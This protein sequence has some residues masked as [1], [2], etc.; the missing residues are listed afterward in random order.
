MP[1]SETT[2]SADEPALAYRPWEPIGFDA[3]GSRAH[4]RLAAADAGPALKLPTANDV[5]RIHQE[6]HRAGYD[7]GYDEGTARARMEAA[8]L[9]S[10]VENLE[11]SLAELDQ[12][13]ASEM[14]GLVVEITR[15][16]LRQTLALN[17][18]VMLTVVRDALAQ[19]PQQ[20]AAI[21]VNPEDAAL[22]RTYLGDQ[23]GPT[24][25]RLLEDAQISRGG[26]R[27]EAAGSRIDA[28]LEMRWRRVIES[29][30]KTDQWIA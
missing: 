29:L 24:G 30:G 18:E 6:A 16:V 5:E 11:K 7:A 25:H 4:S 26:C 12:E 14:L 21:H 28:T 9:N 10:L 3:A 13:V 15:Q 27:I 23:L 8:R 1:T 22:V 2:L 19:L 17:P 20:H